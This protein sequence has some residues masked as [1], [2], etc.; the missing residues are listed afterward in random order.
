MLVKSNQGYTL[1]QVDICDNLRK[2][3]QCIIEILLGNIGTD[4]GIY[5][6]Y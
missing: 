5:Y 2:I 3:F 1:I 6:F 4:A